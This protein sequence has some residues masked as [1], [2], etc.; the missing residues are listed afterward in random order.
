MVARELLELV[1]GLDHKGVD[2]LEIGGDALV[3]D[4]EE[5]LLGFLDNGVEVI[6]GVVAQGR[7]A[8]RGID[9][10]AQ[11]GLPVDDVC[12]VRPVGHRKAVVAE[13]DDVC[14]PAH[15]VE[16]SARLEPVCEGELVDGAGAVVEIFH[17][18]EDLLVGRAV[19]LLCGELHHRLFGDFWRK[20]HRSED[21]LLG[22]DVLGHHALE[23][24]AGGELGA[25]LVMI[26]G[27]LLAA[28]FSHG[29]PPDART[30]M[31]GIARGGRKAGAR[32]AFPIDC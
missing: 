10:L 7:D 13:F 5:E 19:E 4:I 21:R 26:C 9:E 1:E 11:H 31:Q 24:V 32:G 18:L 14:P 8:H 22:V 23:A 30:G 15:G 3:G 20:H 27:V 29:S 6:W 16:L 2:L 25:V 12:M 28:L 17:S